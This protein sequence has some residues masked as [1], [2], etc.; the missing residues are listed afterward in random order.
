MGADGHGGAGA[1]AWLGRVGPHS[2]ER[3]PT[4]HPTAP[5]AQREGPSLPNVT[6]Y[7]LCYGALGARG[8]VVIFEVI[9]APAGL[10]AGA[11]LVDDV[12]PPA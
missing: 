7:L 5:E 1:E 3:G 11:V 12:P 2:T 10:V 8:R 6:V 4:V 9:E